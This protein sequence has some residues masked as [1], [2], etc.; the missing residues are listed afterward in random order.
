MKV[1][2]YSRA[3]RASVL[4]FVLLSAA[5]G[6]QRLSHA[7][8][9]DDTLIYFENESTEQAA[10][11]AVSGARQQ[12]IGTVF[13]LQKATLRLPSSMVANGTVNLFARLL[14]RGEMP[15]SGAIAVRPGARYEV[16][17]TADRRAMFV[18]P[19]QP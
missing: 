15:S 3:T 7:Q 14:A 11:Y 5:C 17:L 16:R 13:S 2:A 6:R 1:L 9:E 10:V 12:R 19:G 8:P 18:M 4:A